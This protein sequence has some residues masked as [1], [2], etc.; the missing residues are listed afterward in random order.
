MGSALVPVRSRE[1]AET[2]TAFQPT[3]WRSTVDDVR[4]MHM[5]RHDQL[6]ELDLTST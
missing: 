6:T 5:Y 3:L 1:L 4:H 2:P